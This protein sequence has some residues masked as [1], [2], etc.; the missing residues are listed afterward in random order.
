MR[1]GQKASPVRVVR[2]DG[3]ETTQAAY[4]SWELAAI[5]NRGGLSP[6]QKATRRRKQRQ[7]KTS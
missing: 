2:A 3:T 7:R 5:G 6:R 4:T 1:R